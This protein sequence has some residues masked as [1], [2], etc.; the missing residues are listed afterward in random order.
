MERQR[1]LP[2]S[3]SRGGIAL[4]MLGLAI[5]VYGGKPFLTGARTAEGFYRVRNGLEQAISRGLAYAPYA[6]LVWCETGTPDLGPV[7]FSETGSNGNRGRRF[8]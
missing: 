6:D 7:S 5:F 4:T 3:P 8:F 2:F 1:R